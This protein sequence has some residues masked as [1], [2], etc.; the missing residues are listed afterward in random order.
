MQLQQPLQDRWQKVDAKASRN[1]PHC[2]ALDKVTRDR[3]MPQRANSQLRNSGV[4]HFDNV[5]RNLRKE[6]EDLLSSNGRRFA[7]KGGS[8]VSSHVTLGGMHYRIVNLTQRETKD[9]RAGLSL[10]RIRW[11]RDSEL[12][13][14]EQVM[15]H[16]IESQ[17]LSAELY[18][19]QDGGMFNVSDESFECILAA[20]AACEDSP[21]GL[22]ET[23]AV[24]LARIA[25]KVRDATR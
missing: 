20:S 23:L 18:R 7:R 12:P 2:S 1:L 24:S 5:C 15:E 3:V 4:Q 13:D 8:A 16:F 10:A 11:R 17:R 6:L 14:N 9:L 22:G 21:D 19:L 25:A